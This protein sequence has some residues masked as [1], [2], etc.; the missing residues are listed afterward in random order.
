MDFYL[1]AVVV[2]FA[3]AV[4]DL[5][6]GVS[7]DA[8]NFLNSAIGSKVASRR[9]IMIVASLGIFIGATFSSGMMEIARK[10]IF[11]PEHFFLTEIMVIFLAVMIT[12]VILLDL[13]NTFGMP[14]STTVSIV[15]EL[16]GAAVV[17]ALI[18]IAAAGEGFSALSQYIN[19]EKAL[20]IIAGIVLSVVVAFTIGVLVQYVSRLLF[21]FGYQKR[22]KRVGAI[23]AGFALTALSYFLVI[24]GLKG[25]SFVSGSFLGWINTNTTVILLILFGGWTLVA[26]A[27]IWLRVNML[28]LIVLLGTFALAMAFA[29]NDLVN[30][31]GVPIAGFESFMAWTGSGVAA[32]AF[33]MESLTEPVRTDS[34]LLLAA[35]LIMV[36]TL[37]F[38]KKARSV[39]E[40]EV[41]LGRQDE[42]HERFTP[43]GLSRMIVRAS[44][45]GGRLL[46]ALI[47]SRWLRAAEANFTPTPPTNEPD[48]PAFDL[49]RASVNLTVAS[50]LI[51]LATSLKLPLSTTYVSFMV[52]M[53]ASLADRAWDRESAVYR[54][55]G[56]LNVIGGWFLTAV[57][58]FSVSGLFALL[59]HAFGSP[60][61]A[62]LLA[63]ALFSIFR[64]I[65]V[66]RKREREKQERLRAVAGPKRLTH[67]AALEETTRGI[68]HVLS[69]IRQAYEDALNGLFEENLGKLRQARHAIK[70]LKRQN[71]FLRS[72]LHH[73]IRRIDEA[74]AASS[75]MYL[76]F[77][78]IVQ[79]IVQSS[80]F[81]VEACNVHVQ[82]NHKPLT[83][84]Q[85]EALAALRKRM[86]TY[87]RAV[88]SQVQHNDFEEI[89]EALDEK[90]QLLRQLGALFEQ[91]VEGVKAQ[92]YGSKNTDLFVSLLLESKDLAA[93]AARFLKFYH[94]HLIPELI[95]VV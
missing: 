94:R 22:M 91:H 4:S 76:M 31:I 19:T 67:P 85:T 92:A 54:V 24:K 15:F 60:V 52:A 61:V 55:A 51:A 36:L 47:P 9:T 56:V 28:S 14:T 45:D 16:L 40:T 43:N 89:S 73:Y 29:G 69:T 50:M 78:D 90:N 21:S 82:N 18:K 79:D 46:T 5:M 63:V 75:R 7:N 64:S 65:V 80:E 48:P 6:V 34:L 20:L 84:N 71:E 88:A 11:N 23:W 68:A 13:F 35:G 95:A 26:Q 81:I 77:Y 25:A 44:R 87:L 38:S 59:I 72:N 12:D 53:G 62:V 66:H 10:G 49:V 2:L 33:T 42:G 58:A 1:I 74:D 70:A 37:W 86:D 27:L 30:F 83:Q 39:T 93:I 57:V 17:V 32:D 3:L 41:N 8:V